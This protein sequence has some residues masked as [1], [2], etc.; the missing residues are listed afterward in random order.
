MTEIEQKYKDCPQGW[1]GGALTKKNTQ[2]SEEVTILAYKIETE[3][4]ATKPTDRK[5]KKL[6]VGEE[7]N[8]TFMPSS[9]TVNWSVEGNKGSIAPATGTT[10]KYTAHNEAAEGKV[11]VEFKGTNKVTSF[12]VIQP[13]GIRLEAKSSQNKKNPLQAGFIA[14]IY[15]TPDDVNFEKVIIYEGVGKSIATGYFSSLNDIDH[16][17]GPD[18]FPSGF[19]AGKGTKLAATDT[20]VTYANVT[21]YSNG[22]FKWPIGWHYKLAGADKPVVTL[23]HLGELTWDAG[24]STATLSTSKG[25]ESTTET[26]P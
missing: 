19:V 10:T 18:L 13:S 16:A 11:K 5:R 20:V 22:T 17:Q 26:N 14:D 8:L 7:V 15:V 23:E 3:T 25:G 21:P 9:I 4:V 12:T 2:A 24:T 6:G 1:T